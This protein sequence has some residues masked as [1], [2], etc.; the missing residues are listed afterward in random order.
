MRPHNVFLN[1]AAGVGTLCYIKLL[2]WPG[3]SVAHLGVLSLSEV[4][5]FSPLPQDPQSNSFCNVISIGVVLQAFIPGNRNNS[6]VCFLL[7]IFTRC[8]P[9]LLNV[10]RVLLT[11]AA[12]FGSRCLAMIDSKQKQVFRFLATCEGKGG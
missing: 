6:I 3:L 9:P 12:H 5:F 10:S 2:S 4:M 1:V 8:C 11:R 7:F